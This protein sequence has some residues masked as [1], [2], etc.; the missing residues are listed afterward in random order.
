MSFSKAISI[1]VLAGA[2]AALTGCATRSV[3]QAENFPPSSQQ[4]VRAAGHWELISEEVA[5]QT[6]STLDKAGI[7]ANTQLYVGLPANPSAFDVSFRDMLITKLTQIGAHV[8]QSPGQT[9]DVSYATQVV[10]H[11]TNYNEHDRPTNT[12]MVLTTTVTRAGQYVARKTDVYYLDNADA[13]LF[14]G[15]SYRNVNM[16]VVSQ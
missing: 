7:P 13:R 11:T 4:K 16:K 12:E 8:Q 15:P 3:P 2:V 10:R 5:A 6:L 14:M 9:L 1:A